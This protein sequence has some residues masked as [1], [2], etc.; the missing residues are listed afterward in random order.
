MPMKPCVLCIRLAIIILV[1]TV[2]VQANIT[3]L[4]PIGSEQIF[5]EVTP[6]NFPSP[7]LLKSPGIQKAVDGYLKAQNI[8]FNVS[9]RQ[10]TLTPLQNKL[11]FSPQ[12]LV[13]IV[14]DDNWSFNN[15]YG[16]QHRV[17]QS[18][19][20]VQ[21]INAP[22]VLL[23]R[24]M[25]SSDKPEYLGSVL[26]HET[27]HAVM[28]ALYNG[29]GLPSVQGMAHDYDSITSPEFAFVEGFA[30]YYAAGCVTDTGL[31]RQYQSQNHQELNSTEGYVASILI[32]LHNSFGQDDIFTVMANNKPHNCLTFLEAYL[33]AYPQRTEQVLT[34]LHQ[35]SPLWPSEN[36][37]PPNAGSRTSA[38]AN[39][40]AFDRQ[41]A[42]LQAAIQ[43]N[44]QY[45]HNIENYLQELL[46]HLQRITLFRS[47]L[48]YVQMPQ[49]YKVQ[50]LNQIEN[51]SK[52]IL[53]FYEQYAKIT[54]QINND[55]E[56][57]LARLR[58]TGTDSHNPPNPQP[59][60]YKVQ[61]QESP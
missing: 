10:Q 51:D 20:Q 42:Q 61:R 2:Y 45:L 57:L 44:R 21:N 41:T 17:L 36:E 7:E 31:P 26:A 47:Q 16:A 24:N 22:S 50:L 15:M 48:M 53:A 34:I 3:F 32:G 54:Y 58:M 25:P 40:N 28:H 19:G 30:E 55:H 5:S 33:Q 60:G 6:T 11:F 49:T 38:T 14:N 46:S 9:T 43:Q 12:K 52:K 27:G 59:S 18:N 35:C 37:F 1:C 29:V 56:E 39:Q 4:Q 13:V 8:A 23:G